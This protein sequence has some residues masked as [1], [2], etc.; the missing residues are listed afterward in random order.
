MADDSPEFNGVLR[1]R[2]GF[3]KQ[4]VVALIESRLLVCWVAW[5][6]VS[7]SVSYA[8]TVACLSIRAMNDLG[9]LRVFSGG[10]GGG[11]LKLI[12]LT[13]HP[14][15]GMLVDEIKPFRSAGEMFAVL[16]EGLDHRWRTVEKSVWHER[17]LQRRRKRSE[18][19][20]MG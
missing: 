7:R 11:T 14:V 1:S 12:H 8:D 2:M 4:M 10:E 19:H 6:H 9:M 17:D 20:G 3:Q 16:E 13:K 18:G 15:S 5:L